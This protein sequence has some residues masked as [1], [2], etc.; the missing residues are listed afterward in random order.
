MEG[1]DDMY[2]ML[3]ISRP[4]DK[5]PQHTNKDRLTDWYDVALQSGLDILAASKCLTMLLLFPCQITVSGDYDSDGQLTVSVLHSLDPSPHGV[6]TP[7]GAI[8]VRSLRSGG[9]ATYQPTGALSSAELAQLKVSSEVCRN[10][11]RTA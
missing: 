9:S 3:A 4:F 7:R 8:S 2:H 1:S 6:F 11:I 5:V 10:Q